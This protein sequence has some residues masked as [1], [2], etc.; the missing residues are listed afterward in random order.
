MAS[1]EAPTAAPVALVTGAAGFIGGYV[2]EEFVAR[3][4]H[5]V[6]LVHRRQSPRLGE[7]SAAGRATVVRGDATDPDLAERTILPA[8]GAGGLAAIVHCAGRASDVGRWAAFRRANLDAVRNLAALAASTQSCRFVFISTTDVYGLRDFHGEAEDELPLAN[9]TS[10]PYPEF[11]IQAEEHIRH[12]LPPE[13]W[14]V[15]RPAAVWGVG[16]RTLTPRIVSFLRSSPCIMHFGRWRGRNRWPLA[17]VRNVASAA[18]AAATLPE[19]GGLATNVLDDEF[20][21]CDELYRL[22]AEVYLPGRKLAS[23]T[24]PVWA[25]W[26]WAAAVSALS[27]ALNL[28]HPLA[29]PSLYA[30]RTV[31]SSLDFGNRRL[32]ALLDAAG[33]R[34]VTRDEGLHELAA[35][36]RQKGPPAPGANCGP[37]GSWQ[38]THPEVPTDAELPAGD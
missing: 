34:L 29:D 36:A 21:T 14:A 7:L 38:P 35:E 24:V 31:S 15:I 11:K 28:P 2:V 16:D 33:R 25:A 20:T 22:L 37:A 18:Y 19:A 12:A 9:N 30:L 10:N 1:S 23:V 6:A 27:G 5:V 3:G 4:W 17:H 32:H 26:P 13:S 8:L